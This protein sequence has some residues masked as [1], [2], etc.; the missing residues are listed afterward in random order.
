MYVTV[1]LHFCPR[2]VIDLYLR[3]NLNEEHLVK[4][5]YKDHC[6]LSTPQKYPTYLNHSIFD[7]FPPLYGT[8]KKKG[9]ETKLEAEGKHTKDKGLNQW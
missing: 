1:Y 3:E 7:A 2:I 5:F 4:R 9:K 6:F 8:V